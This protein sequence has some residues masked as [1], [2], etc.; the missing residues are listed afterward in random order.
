MPTGTVKWFDTERGF[1]FIASDEGED[2]FVHASALPTSDPLRNGARVEFGVA[3]GRRG[4]QALNVVILEE[5]PSLTKAARKPAESL[6]SVV[7]DLI[8]L[9]DSTSNSL[10]RGQ[11]P[12]D[13]R[14]RAL[15]K[16]LRAVAD[17]F[18]VV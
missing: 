4:T 2:V 12:D 11:Y 15:A 3:D 10:R 6:A 7:E 18:D 16:L 9:L 5:P 8:K 1:G 14:S 13:S 17:D